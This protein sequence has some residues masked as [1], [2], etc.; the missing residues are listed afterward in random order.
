MMRNLI[1]VVALILAGCG[2]KHSQDLEISQETKSEISQDNKQNNKISEKPA[3]ISPKNDDFDP[4]Y[5]YNVAMTYVNDGF[6]TYI[7]TPLVW[8]YDAIMPDPI[9]VAF[10]DFFHNAMYPIRLVNNLLQG[11]WAGAWDETKRFAINTTLGFGGLADSASLHY[12]LPKHD[13]D[14]GQTLAS[15]GVGEGFPVVLPLLGQSNL[16]DMVGLGVDSLANPISYVGSQWHHPSVINGARHYNEFSLGW[17]DYHRLREQNPH[18]YETLKSVYSQ[19]RAK[20]I[21]E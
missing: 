8:G 12:D 6:Y 17:R 7:Y 2:S 19:K 18:L 3:E 16:R 13:E 20:E 11:K 15:W 9:Q 10:K 21:A 4:L 1:F 14:F 5:G